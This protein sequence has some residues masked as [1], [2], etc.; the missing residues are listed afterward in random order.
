MINGDAGEECGVIGVL[1]P[2]WPAAPLLTDG[3]FTLQHRGQESAGVAVSRGRDIE[4]RLGMG[5][6]ADALGP[7]VHGLTG[8]LGIG[9]VRYS[10]SGA[11]SLANAQPIREQGPGR[12]PFAIAHNGNL[13]GMPGS[14]GSDSRRLA[15][16]LAG[17][18]GSLGDVMAEV[19]PGVR[20]AYSLVAMADGTLYAARD[21]HGFRPLSVG[22]LDGGGW[23]VASE[24]AALDALGAEFLRDVEPGEIAEFD[25]R[26]TRSQRFGGGRSALCAFEHV[27]FARADSV[28]DKRSV[29]EVRRDLGAALAREAPADA[30][31]VIPVPDTA[32]VA[33]L[34]YSEES[35]LRYAEGLVRN[36]YV[37]RT[38][39]QP[40]QQDRQGGVRLK[41]RPV[42]QVVAG[43][44][45][46]VVDDSIV[47][48]TSAIQ[49]VALLRAAGA[50]EVHVRVASPAVRWLCFFGV[51]IKG[52]DE[53]AA[54]GRTSEEMGRLVGADSLAYLSAEALVAGAR[55]S[56]DLCTACF[57]GDYPAADVETEAIR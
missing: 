11:S 2:G 53:L 20:G 7:R 32:R 12:P 5:L 44:R 8:S 1:A 25:A 43:H 42:E 46:V 36:I 27:Y 17:A 54:R 26:G 14:A 3:L 15:G 51:D 35:G 21:P 45:V 47:R 13:T 39:I 50:T 38:F 52:G 24:T 37:S 34:G 18:P 22:V 55:G 23:V 56:M 19:L 49:V 9:H 28:L 29:Y 30:D 40:S 41:L 48:A 16:L 57:T 31:L 33:A 4:T 10:T 6:V